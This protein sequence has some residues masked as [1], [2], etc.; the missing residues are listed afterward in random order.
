M[1]YQNAATIEDILSYL[2][3]KKEYYKKIL[4]LTEKQEEAIQSNNTRELNLIITEKENSIKEIKRLDKLNIKIQEELRSNIRNL[5]LDKRLYSLL[6]QLQSI[7]TKIRN[8]D[9]DSITLL[10]SSIKSTK[11][12]LNRLSKR[13]RAQQSMRYQGIQPSRFVDVIQ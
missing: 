8:Y 10:H 9:L 6:N 11:T 3:R 12:R 1:E 7:I 13:K 5:T 4:E 2:I